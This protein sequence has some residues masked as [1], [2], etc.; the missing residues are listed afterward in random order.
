MAIQN[1]HLLTGP[2]AFCSPASAKSPILKMGMVGISIALNFFACR[3]NGRIAANFF[4]LL[5]YA[6]P[7]QRS[8]SEKRQPQAQRRDLQEP[9]P[10]LCPPQIFAYK[11]PLAFFGLSIAWEAPARASVK[12]FK[13]QIRVLSTIYPLRIAAISVLY[14]DAISRSNS[15]HTGKS[16]L[17]SHVQGASCGRLSRNPKPASTA[18][19]VWAGNFVTFAPSCPA[20][21]ALTGKTTFSCAP[22]FTMPPVSSSPPKP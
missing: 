17:S 2:S 3:I 9:T 10:R 15:T 6:P 1:R 19:P 4:T 13:F 8:S 20:A 21:W 12:R 5:C 14:L 11:S 7:G 22:R 16:V 18:A